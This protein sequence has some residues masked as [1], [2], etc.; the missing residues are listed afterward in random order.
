M[1]AGSCYYVFQTQADAQAAVAAIDTRA[2][3]L[4]QAAGFETQGAN[5]VG[6]N[7][8]TGQPQPSAQRTTTWF[9]PIQTLLGT[10]VVLSPRYQSLAQQPCPLNPALTILQYVIQDLIADTLATDPDDGTW[11]PLPAPPPS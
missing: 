10:W 6:N 3:A 11:F 5:V 9:V 8:A 7:L 2:L 4:Y 1:M